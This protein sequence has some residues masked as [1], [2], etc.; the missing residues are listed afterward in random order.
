MFK[1]LKEK[2]YCKNI[3]RKKEYCKNIVDSSWSTFFKENKKF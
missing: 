3:Y 2:E 1:K